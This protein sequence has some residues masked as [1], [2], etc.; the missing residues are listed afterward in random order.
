[1]LQTRIPNPRQIEPSGSEFMSLQQT[2]SSAFALFGRQYP[3]MIFTLLLCVSLAS[4]YLLSLPKRYS[5]TAERSEEH[6][7]ELQSPC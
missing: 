1:M 6:T 4:V 2:V 5:S 3:L 7:S